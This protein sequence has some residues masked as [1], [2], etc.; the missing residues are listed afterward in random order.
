MAAT[1]K[2]SGDASPAL[3]GK[4]R[5]RDPRLWGALFD[6]DRRRRHDAVRAIKALS[7]EAW[8]A[9]QILTDLPNLHLWQR[10]FAGES[11]A[12]FGD[13]RFSEPHYLPEMLAVPAG[14]VIIGSREFPDEQP[15]HG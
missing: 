6:R 2:A 12:L 3:G 1:S 4:H 9:T 13:P 11:L 7:L 8:Y 15:V 14:R 5:V 10:P